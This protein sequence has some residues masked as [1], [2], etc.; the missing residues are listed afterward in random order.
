MIL[1]AFACCYLLIAFAFCFLFSLFAPNDETLAFAT[2]QLLLICQPM[3]LHDSLN[4]IIL[5]EKCI[6]LGLSDVTQ[7]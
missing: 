1:V 7:R 2:N 4:Q 5:R 6:M 3:P